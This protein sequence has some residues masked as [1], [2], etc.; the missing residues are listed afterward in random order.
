VHVLDHSLVYKERTV[1]EVGQELLAWTY[2]KVAI[3]LEGQPAVMIA[4]KPGGSSADESGWLAQTLNLTNDGTEY[5]ASGK[6]ILP[7]LTAGSDHVP[8]FS[9]PTW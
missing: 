6:V 1:V 9:S 2:D 3:A 5:T 7:V 8:T 4:D